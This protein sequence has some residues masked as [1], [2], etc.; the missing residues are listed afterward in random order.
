MKA[1]LLIGVAAG[2]AVATPML[3]TE[4]GSATEDTFGTITGKV[5]FDGDRPEPLPPLNIGTKESEGCCPPGESMDTTDR[6]VRIDEKG[7]VADVVV[8]LTADGFDREI[9]EEPIVLDQHHCRFGSPVVVVPV[10]AKI[11]YHNSDSV[12]HNIHTYSKKNKPLNNNVA[13]GS[14]DSMLL[15]KDEDFEV[16]CDIH[17]WMLSN[18]YV[19]EATHWAVTNPDGTFTIEGVPPGKYKLEVWHAKLGKGKTDEVTV[20]AGGTATVDYALGEK[21]KKRGRR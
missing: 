14:S 20:E 4:N 6:S 7:G 19:T 13:G 16:K 10:G 8:S 12:N 2:A 5:T 11:T 17:P 15:D 21:K 9:P 18:V 3:G 1:L